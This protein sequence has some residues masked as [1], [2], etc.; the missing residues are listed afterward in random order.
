MRNPKSHAVLSDGLVVTRKNSYRNQRSRSRSRS[1]SAPGSRSLSRQS[2]GSSLKR[3]RSNE[4]IV[5]P[6]F[7]LN[8]NHLMDSQSSLYR[9][10][11]SLSP[12]AGCRHLSCEHMTVSDCERPS[13]ILRSRGSN[14]RVN[15]TSN[16]F[17]SPKRARSAHNSR[18]RLSRSRT[19]SSSRFNTK[20]GS[21]SKLRNSS[22][23]DVRNIFMQN[24]TTI[25]SLEIFN[26]SF[27]L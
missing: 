7:H 10:S 20:V 19:P 27:A 15:F 1:R 18:T 12:D 25:R 11:R 14:P 9:R 3:S 5:T 6:N 16:S 8:H 24:S 4:R 22:N 23:F 21:F 17:T 13:S 26:T 2:R